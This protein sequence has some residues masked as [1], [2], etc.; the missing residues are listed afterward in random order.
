MD[1]AAL[2]FILEGGRLLLVRQA[3]GE[4]YWSLPGGLVEA[5]ETIEQAAVR[6]VREETGL[7]VRLKRVVGIYVKPDEGVLAITFEGEAVGGEAR[8]DNEIAACA[9][10]GL[11]DLPTRVRDHFAERISDFR[12]ASRQIIFKYQ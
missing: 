2:V 9:Y 12:A 6:E 4:Q 3:G 8:A 5:D 10:F 1:V 11:D 7:E